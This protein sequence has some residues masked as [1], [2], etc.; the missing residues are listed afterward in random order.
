[1]DFNISRITT[2]SM[3]RTVEIEDFRIL[4]ILGR[5][6]FS[7]VYLAENRSS[8][9]IN[10][11]KVADISGSVGTKRLKTFKE[12]LLTERNILAS[13]KHPFIVTLQYTFQSGN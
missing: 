2:A 6:G 5:G 12:R 11:L 4:N 10:A 1:M 13:L 8:G 3:F 9:L 7:S